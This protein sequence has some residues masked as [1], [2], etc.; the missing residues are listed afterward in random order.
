MLSAAEASLHRQNGGDRGA[1][2]CHAGAEHRSATAAAKATASTGARGPTAQLRIMA[3]VGDERVDRAEKPPMET[4]HAELPAVR[5]A[6][7]GHGGHAELP[8][9]VQWLRLEGE[10]A[11]DYKDIH[12]FPWKCCLVSLP[13]TLESRNSAGT[14]GT[15]VFLQAFL[16][17]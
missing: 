13:L 6:A 16:Q 3:Q 17:I 5:A 2:H 4:S 1:P 7:R 15:F 11:G 8:R 9:D 12:S 14:R 10:R